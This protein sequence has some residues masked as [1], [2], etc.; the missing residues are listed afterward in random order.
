MAR[1]GKTLDDFSC[2]STHGAF[3]FHPWREGGWAVVFAFKA[4]SPTCTTELFALQ[5]LAAQYSAQ[6]IKLLGIALEPMPV[7]A[8]WLQDLRDIGNCQPAFP[9]ASDTE[10]SASR[11]LDLLDDEA[12]APALLRTAL[13]VC[14]QGRVVTQLTYSINNGR[15]FTELLRTVQALQLTA[16]AKVATPAQWRPG[17]EVMLPPSLAQDEAERRYPE[18]VTLRPYLRMVPQPL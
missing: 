4:M 12:A 18:V 8:R 2:V 9:L 6:G 13:V 10:G 14:P 3:E 15:N 17:G 16:R 1:V 5:Q 11:T 7:I